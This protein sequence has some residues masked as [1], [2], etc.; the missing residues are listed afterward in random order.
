MAHNETILRFLSRFKGPKTGYSCRIPVPYGACI[1]DQ[2]VRFTIFSRHATNVWLL[3]FDRPDQDAPSEEHAL[4]RCGD[5]WH[6]RVK[7]AHAGQYYVYRMD[8][9]N[10]A[11]HRFDSAQWLL[12]PYALAVASMRPWGEPAGLQP[13]KPP[14]NGALFPKG[15]IVKP[16]FGGQSDEKPDIPLRDT[17]IYEL[18]V[19]GYTAHPSSGVSARG[20]Y[21][22]LIEKIPYLQDLGVTA[23]E[24]LPIQEFNELEFMIENH[25]RTNLRNFWGYSTLAFF[26]PNARYATD[27]FHGQQVREFQDMVRAFHKAGIEVLLDI[28]FNHTAEGD[29]SW[30]VYSF[31]GIDNPIYYIVDPDKGDYHNYTGCG[32]TFNCNHP[33]VQDFIVDVL[34]YWT[35]YMHVDGFRFDLASILCRGQ[36]GKPLKKP[37][38]VERIAEDPVLSKVKLI[39]EPW[40]A[41]GLHQVGSFP[42]ARWL[43][44]NDRFRDDVKMFWHG[45]KG[46]T[47]ALATRLCGNADQFSKLTP[48]KSVNFITSHDGFTLYDQVAYLK[49]HNSANGENG[50]DGHNNNISM[51]FGKEGDPADAKIMTMRKRQVK[52]FIATLLLSQGVP[53]ITA[54]DEFGRTQRGNNNAYCQDNEISWVNWDKACENEDILAFTKAMIVFRKQHPALRRATF[55]KGRK[56]NGDRADILWFSSDGKPLDWAVAKSLAFMLRGEKELTGA[57]EDDAHILALFSVDEKE[58]AF[59]LPK[60]PGQ[61]WEI[62][63]ATAAVEFADAN[64]NVLNLPARCVAILTS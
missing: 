1:V 45:D 59:Q 24:L 6:I 8:G 35:Q 31:K 9:P 52:N 56:D 4:Q 5:L 54:G 40:D 16:G 29:R 60:P 49:K 18:H 2:G 10:D 25:G 44:W 14:R 57:Q 33:V 39:A 32:N 47:G 48:L 27:G 50:N 12:D 26:A 30:P 37:P 36:D 17:I 34:R 28:V 43:E 20:A 46:M 63:L 58:V 41:A 61:S 55:L 62:A 23:V 64:R 38:V 7:N 19:R 21:R 11:R 22:G 42:H 53:M 13:G 15:I 3:L 51:N